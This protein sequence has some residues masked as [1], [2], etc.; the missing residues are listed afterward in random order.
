[1][2]TFR[3]SIFSLFFLRCGN[4]RLYFYE[5]NS[6]CSGALNVFEIPQQP[7]NQRKEAERVSTVPAAQ[8]A[9]VVEEP[10]GETRRRNKH[11]VV[12]ALY[13]CSTLLS[14][15]SFFYT[16]GEK[17]PYVELLRQV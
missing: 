4:S 7:G 8:E 11:L 13:L 12:V 3:T 14:S 15:C 2:Q 10:A 17:T 16:V 1:M 9:R 6:S 5:G